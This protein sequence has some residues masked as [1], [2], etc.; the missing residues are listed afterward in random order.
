MHTNNEIEQISDNID[1]IEALAGE[2]VEQ[3]SK[4]IIARSRQPG[5][6]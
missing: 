5:L 1:D 2:Q 6:L 4:R 3:N